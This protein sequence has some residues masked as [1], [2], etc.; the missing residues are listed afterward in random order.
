[1]KSTLTM[2]MTRALAMAAPMFAA[3]Q[4]PMAAGTPNY[5]I[6]PI[7]LMVP[8]APG[9]SNDIM[10]RYFGGQ[11]GERLGKQVVVD[12]RPGGEGIIATDLVAKANPDGYTL[13]MASAAFTMNP[14]V[15]NKLPFDPV[16]DFDWVGMLGSAPVVVCVSS[17]MPVK[18]VQE[19]IALGKSKPNY[20]T[21]ASAGGFMH[22]VS[23]MFRTRAGITGEIVLYK[24][25]APAI[26]DVI[27]GQAHIAVATI[28][29]AGPQL[30]AG[31]LKP[32]AT[33]SA[34][35]AAALPDVPTL[36]EA[37]VPNYEASIWWGWATRAGTPAPILNRLSNEVV[38]IQKLPDT[39]KRFEA[40]GAEI[41]TRTPA[42]MKQWIP[43]DL[44]KWAKVAREAGMP[45]Q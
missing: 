40:E 8:Q 32:L 26:I 1:M 28:V 33:G 38:A 5:P 36:A 19:L 20:L 13:L 17:A 9:G 24:G 10:A 42:E 44:D 45:R 3:P 12:N 29:T 37:G 2:R 35:R 21:I 11:V 34:K 41:L 31:K 43:Q 23:A 16:K 4:Q 14:A 30:R 15:Y 27:S 39:A 25:G 7:R 6:K 22:F 18:T